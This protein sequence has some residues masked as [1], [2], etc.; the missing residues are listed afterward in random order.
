LFLVSYL[1]NFYSIPDRGAEY[2]D[3]RVCP[4]VS[5]CVCL[6]AIISSE[7]HIRSSLIFF[8]HVNYGRGSVL[9][10]RRSDTLRTSISGFMDDV[11]FA[12]KLQAEA[13]R[14]RRQAEAVRLTQPWAWRVGIPIA[15]SVRSRL[16]LAVRAY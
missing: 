14:C 1:F 13:A 9:L 7:L 2:C 15:C 5:V 10:W 12:H 6:S 11:I 8:V 3:E 4:Y 16:L